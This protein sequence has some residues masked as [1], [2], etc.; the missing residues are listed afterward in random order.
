MWACALAIIILAAGF[1]ALAPAAAGV[2]SPIGP[3][4]SAFSTLRVGELQEPDSLNPFVGVLSGSYIIWAHVYDLLVGIGPDLTPIPA[5]AASWQVD[6][7]ELNWTFHLQ[8]NVTWHDGVPF[9]AEDVNFTL[10][11]IWAAS[12]WN[13][14]GCNLALLQSYMG[15]PVNNVGVDAGNI[16]VLDDYTIRIPTYQPKA[17]MLSMFIPIVP[18]HIWSGVA[19]NQATHVTNLPPIGTGMY[20]FTNW[21]RGTYIQLDL[22]TA[23][24]R[25]LPTEDYIDRII[26]TYYKDAAALYNAIIGG[27]EDAT[28]ALPADK[29]ALLPDT[30]LGAP[31]PNVA[32]LA[33]DAIG[34]MEVGACVAS[35]ALIDYYKVQGGRNWLLTNRTVRQALNFAADREDLVQTVLSGYGKPGSTLVPPATPFWHYNVTATENYSFDLQK[36]RDLLDDPKHDGF[37]LKAGQTVPGDYGQNLDPTA[38]NNQDAFIDTNG[39]GIRDVVNAAQ[40][41][42][43]DDWGSSAPN[44]NLL[45]FTIS[46]RNYDVAGQ[47]AAQR[48]ETWWGQVGIQVTTDIVSESKLIGITYACSEDLYWWGWG[49]DVDPDFA[50]SVMTTAQILNWQDAWYSNKT[51]D[52]WYL[53]QQR[54]VDMYQRQQTIWNMQKLL[55]FD[56][57]YLIAWYDQT[58]T[59]IRSDL[60]TNWGDWNAHPGLGLTGYGNDLVMLTM[61]ST[62]GVVTNQCPTRPVIEGT[63]PRHVYVNASTTFTANATDPENDPLTW[64]FSWDNAA[65]N[66]TTV[67]TVSGV[68]QAS[69]SF[70]WN[71]TGS[72]N[73]TV[74]VN[75][76]L[77]GSYVTSLPFQVIADPLPAQYGWLTGTVRDATE[78]SHPPISGATV[79][80]VMVGSTQVFSDTTDAAGQYN[81]T[82]AAGEY[83]VVAG[84]ALY[85]PQALTGIV[86][87]HGSATV[88]NFNLTQLR[89]YLVGTVS[90]S[91]GGALEGVTLYVTGPRSTSALSNAQGHYNVTLPPGVYNV[92]A[93][94]TGYVNKSQHNL[95]VLP[96]LETV[97]NFS[98]DPI[99]TPV[100]GLSTWEI[101]AIVAAVVVVVGAAAWVVLRRRKKA[102]EI[103]AP[104]AGP[105][106]PPGPKGPP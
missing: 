77:C 70:A 18:E 64:I 98:L 99:A 20:A 93:S 71:V 4:P 31:S 74:S 39:D 34:F 81:L 10:R 65:A 7:S 56:A 102:E 15:D 16:T 87:T 90:S 60:F 58:L 38:T 43:G 23:Y 85:I 59:A 27:T 32:K 82:L 75:D 67:N 69:A 103:E 12:T 101:L 6:S 25:L 106:T 54:Q 24:W 46:I 53:L 76:N 62:A 1:S 45:S 55:Y 2:P 28:D 35:D 68:T 42:A 49:M 40:V 94:R 73:V 52:A 33:V 66:T 11:Y 3:K 37:T 92:T 79:A 30:I 80:A 48:L 95:T 5:L 47:N 26:I 63:P 17:N 21:V 86:V 36:A 57:P 100:T 50:L 88:A 72:F 91:A 14:I 78:A 29:F 44:S 97:A 105:Q 104:P 41:V 9:T 96:Y 22:N 61:R 51:Y 19:C 13:P 83:G 8:H 89:G 84:Q